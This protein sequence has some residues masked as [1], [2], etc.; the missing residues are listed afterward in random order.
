MIVQPGEDTN[1]PEPMTLD[2]LAAYQERDGDL[3]YHHMPGLPHAFAYEASTATDYSM[4]VATDC[5]NIP[6]TCGAMP[7]ASSGEPASCGG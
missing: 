2:L 6:A 3:T 7:Y 5:G 1:V 4:Y